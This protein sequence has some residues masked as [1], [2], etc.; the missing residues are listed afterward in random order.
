MRRS[1]RLPAVR[2]VTSN[3]SARPQGW[4]T[5]PH[6]AQFATLRAGRCMR[7]QGAR[8]RHTSPPAAHTPSS[9]NASRPGE[10][11]MGQATSAIRSNWGVRVRQRVGAIVRL[12]RGASRGLDA[13][14]AMGC[15][16]VAA[17]PSPARCHQRRIAG[18]HARSPTPNRACR[19]ALDGRSPL[20]PRGQVCARSHPSAATSR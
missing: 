20:P 8:S 10:V 5:R 4:P 3:S 6:R 14:P 18:R 1:W 15:T 19:P 2:E 17:D 13:A 16:S 12:P 7:S 9:S 11:R